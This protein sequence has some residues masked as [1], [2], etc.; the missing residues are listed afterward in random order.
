MKYERPNVEVLG[1]A[2]A[3]VQFNDKSTHNAPDSIQPNPTWTDGMAY[4]SD[5]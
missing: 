5:E 4:Q 1:A 3:V 2:T